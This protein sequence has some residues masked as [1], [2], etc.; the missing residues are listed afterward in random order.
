M[1]YCIYE[2]QYKVWNAQPLLNSEIFLL[3][4]DL[5]YK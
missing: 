5:T 2:Y 3:T 1:L 4:F